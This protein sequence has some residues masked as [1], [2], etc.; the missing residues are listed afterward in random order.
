[1]N[2]VSNASVNDQ[3]SCRELFQLA[4]SNACSAPN[5]QVR[6]GTDLTDVRCLDLQGSANHVPVD[7]Q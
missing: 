6:V 3:P 1:M 2:R 7:R 4:R 5:E